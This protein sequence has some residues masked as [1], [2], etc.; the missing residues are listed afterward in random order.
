MDNFNIKKFQEQIEFLQV[1]SEWFGGG[2]F[3]T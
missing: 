3:L 2:A 1:G